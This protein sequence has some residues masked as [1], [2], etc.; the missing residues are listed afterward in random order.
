LLTTPDDSH[1]SR[2]SPPLLFPFL[3]LPRLSLAAMLSRLPFPAP[4]RCLCLIVLSVLLASPV[5]AI[6]FNL[7]AEKYP[8]QSKLLG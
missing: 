6:K 7:E 1:L 8:T 5:V 4:L 3:P 2:T